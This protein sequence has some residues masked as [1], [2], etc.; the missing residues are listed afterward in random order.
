MR[1]KGCHLSNSLSS[2]G[3]WKGQDLECCLRVTAL[4]YRSDI[5][6]LYLNITCLIINS[7]LPSSGYFLSSSLNLDLRFV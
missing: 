4:S 5:F 3:Y 7:Y 1:S 6:N 2:G